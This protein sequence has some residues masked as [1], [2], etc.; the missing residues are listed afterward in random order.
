MSHNV[1]TMFFSFFLIIHS[2]TTVLSSAMEMKY[3]FLCLYYIDTKPLNLRASHEQQN[4]SSIHHPFTAPL[5]L[6]VLSKC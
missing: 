2:A 3:R 5:I 4:T 1:L 6:F